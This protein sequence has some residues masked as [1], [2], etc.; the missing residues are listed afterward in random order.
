ME[1]KVMPR[2]ISS[3]TSATGISETQTHLLTINY[4]GQNRSAIIMVP[5]RPGIEYM[6][7]GTWSA[8]YW[9]IGQAFSSPTS[10][11]SNVYSNLL[12]IWLR[13]GF[14]TE[15]LLCG[16]RTSWISATCFCTCLAPWFI[17]CFFSMIIFG[18]LDVCCA[19]GLTLWC[20]WHSSQ[21]AVFHTQATIQRNAYWWNTIISML[22]I[23]LYI[24][25]SII[26]LLTI[27]L[28]LLS[29]TLCRTFQWL[30]IMISI[31]AHLALTQL[32]GITFA[33]LIMCSTIFFP[34]VVRGSL[35]IEEIVLLRLSE[36]YMLQ[37][38][39]S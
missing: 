39:H 14:K 22:S 5:G 26:L 15:L 21:C 19:D 20:S 2:P 12:L 1:V 37:S 7:P 34:G 27:L 29:S 8:F 30:C 36:G 17:V 24:N 23:R 10:S 35:L 25:T 16:S 31:C 11:S 18:C 4:I 33:G 38:L 9:W 32:A 28:S 13:T 6:L 3:A